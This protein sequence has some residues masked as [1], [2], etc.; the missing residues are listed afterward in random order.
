MQ[1]GDL[2]TRDK[3]HMSHGKLFGTIVKRKPLEF[4][5]GPDGKQAYQYKIYWLCCQTKICAD[6]WWID[7]FLEAVCK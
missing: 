4:C 6:D 3:Y 1:V 5:L 2:V 7:Q